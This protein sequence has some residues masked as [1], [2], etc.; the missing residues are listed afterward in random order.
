MRPH[1]FDPVSAVL[2]VAATGGGVLVIVGADHAV[3]STAL[4]G[5][6]AAI[7][8]AVGVVVLPW[9]RRIRDTGNDAGPLE[10]DLVDLDT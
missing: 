4:G 10:S 9:G 8:I 2:G 6:V 5:W 3:E 7:A 1:R